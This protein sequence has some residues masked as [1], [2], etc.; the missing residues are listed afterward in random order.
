MLF[1]DLIPPDAR[2]LGTMGAQAILGVGVLALSWALVYVFRTWRA[3]AEKLADKNDTDRKEQRGEYL[4][5]LKEIT[6]AN[7]AAINQLAAESKANTNAITELAAELKANTTAILERL[8][9]LE[10]H[11]PSR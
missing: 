10:L 8:D 11:I 4:Q 9:R 2:D 3:D 1:A 5:S 7:T 6:S